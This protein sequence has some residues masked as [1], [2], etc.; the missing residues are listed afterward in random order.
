MASQDKQ[1]RRQEAAT[2]VA[3]SRGSLSWWGEGT[4]LLH[5]W[6]LCFCLAKGAG[7]GSS[8]PEM[9]QMVAFYF[10][11]DQPGAKAFLPAIKKKKNNKTKTKGLW[12]GAL[13]GLGWGKSLCLSFQ[14][15]HKWCFVVLSV[16]SPRVAQ[17]VSLQLDTTE[18]FNFYDSVISEDAPLNPIFPSP[19]NCLWLRLWYWSSKTWKWSSTVA[20]RISNKCVSKGQGWDFLGFFQR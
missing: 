10:R 13:P 14:V 18:Q 4:M 17:R 8:S 2:H 20:F 3:G 9:S 1:P 15:V 16:L 12:C 5:D 6:H 11:Q 7:T 19:H